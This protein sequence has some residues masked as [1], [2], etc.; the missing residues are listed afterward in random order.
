M[1][2]L[3]L[4]MLPGVWTRTLC[5]FGI[6]SYRFIGITPF[7]TGAYVKCHRCSKEGYQSWV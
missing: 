3:L 6:H 4:L 7:P 5:R 1:K 2:I